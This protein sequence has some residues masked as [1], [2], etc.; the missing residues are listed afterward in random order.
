MCHKF[1]TV[2]IFQMPNKETN[3]VS[4][5]AKSQINRQMCL[6]TNFQHEFLILGRFGQLGLQI[7]KNPNGL[8]EG[9]F[10]YFHGQNRLHCKLFPIKSAGD[11]RVAKHTL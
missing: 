6:K 4:S 2:Y 11:P 10:L 1:P 8:F 5:H 7:K 9:R 3:C